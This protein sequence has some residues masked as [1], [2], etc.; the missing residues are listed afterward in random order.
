VLER[1]TSTM[2]N[3]DNTGILGNITW[4]FSANIV[5]RLVGLAGQIILGWLLVP[6]EFGVYALAVSLSA[7]I[8]VLR[9]G[10]VAQVAV[11]KGQEFSANTRL[12][13]RYA[14]A[15]DFAAAL[16]LSCLAIPFLL[17]LSAVGNIL[18]GIAISLPL[19]TSASIYKAHLLVARR[20]REIAYI[21]LFSSLIWQV[22]LIGFAAS[23]L[24]ASSFAIPPLLQATFENIAYRL[25]AKPTIEPRLDIQPTRTEYLQLFRSARWIMAS[26]AMLS[27]ATTGDYFAV[28]MLTDAKVVGIYFF[29]FQ[30]IAAIS[31]PINSAFETVLP[32][33]FTKLNENQGRQ[34]EACLKVIRTILITSIPL[35]IM[36]MMV[37]PAVMHP[38]WQG[39]WDAAIPSAQILAL[40]IPA[41]LVTS[42]IRALLEAR[43]W[44][45]YRFVLLAIY[46]VGGMSTAALGTLFHNVDLIA[47]SVTA[48]Y[49]CFAAALLLL[50][51]GYG[52]N[53][54]DIAQRCIPAIVINGVAL[55][56]SKALSMM[57]ND[58]SSYIFTQ[59]VEIVSYLIIALLLNA[60]FLKDVWSAIVITP[61]KRLMGTAP[62]AI[63]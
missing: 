25:S 30:L 49:I 17:R 32:V 24:G 5:T 21:T 38:V 60:V 45:R 46:G 33:T 43:G 47:V 54:R 61:C 13:Y 23:G 1:R 16:L 9:S 59:L 55:M 40:C 27:L 56:I 6:E 58:S 42:S 18:L 39:K 37:A 11:Q 53:W 12:Y 44:W 48:F 31:T 28:G 26:T 15:F 41:W 22:S 8:T 4:M 51:R 35:S 36:I 62:N 57:I 7:F 29:A 3:R 63:R 14:L 10:G 52:V 2:P 20:F 19:G 50:L 34:M